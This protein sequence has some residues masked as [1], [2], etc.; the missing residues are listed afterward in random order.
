MGMKTTT[1]KKVAVL[2][3]IIFFGQMIQPTVVWALT[4]GPKQ[5]E[6]TAF[7]PATTTQMVDL[8]SG[9]F[10]YN[11]PLFELPGPNGGYPF[12]LAYHA[13]IGM[14]Q[15]ASWVGLGWSLN[16]GALNRQMRGLPDEFK[17][18]DVTKTMAMK[19][20]VTVGVGGGV[21]VEVFGANALKG[22]L[23]MTLFHNNYK[24]VGYNIDGGFGYSYIIAAL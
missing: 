19:P 20:S 4:S 21:G 6:F 5:P 7:E 22:N 13:G 15:E 10:T 3:L 11:I 9:D 18:D 8:F 17:G 24:G 16:P 14:E 23:G 12:N 1:R 2:L